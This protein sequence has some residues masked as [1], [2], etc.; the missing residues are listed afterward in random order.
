MKDQSM[1]PVSPQKSEEILPSISIGGFTSGSRSSLC[2]SLPSPM[3][4]TVS[5][6]KDTLR[7]LRTY[8][9]T[10]PLSPNKSG[11]VFKSTTSRSFSP[12]CKP[13]DCE[14]VATP[15]CEPGVTSTPRLLR[16]RNSSL[17]SSTIKSTISMLPISPLKYREFSGTSGSSTPDLKQSNCE[18]MTSPVFETGATSTPSSLTP[19]S[20]IKEPVS[21]TKSAHKKIQRYKASESPEEM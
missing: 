13:S 2:E 18:A 15:G 9:P 21:V 14:T 8:S 10:Q 11:E 7:S 17:S 19:S 20:A 3:S 5:N 1:S 16:A 12:D 4:E 6:A